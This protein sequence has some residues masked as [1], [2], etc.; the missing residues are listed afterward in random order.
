MVHFCSKSTWPFWRRHTLALTW[1]LHETWRE[2]L[3]DDQVIGSNPC[4]KSHATTH[5]SMYATMSQQ[6][7]CFRGRQRWKK[8][9]TACSNTGSEGL[10][11]TCLTAC[12]ICSAFSLSTPAEDSTMIQHTCSMHAFD[13]PTLCKCTSCL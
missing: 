12:P 9:V 7:S 5:W 6:T 3:V 11:P 13:S 8:L 4:H 10:R 1:L 2:D